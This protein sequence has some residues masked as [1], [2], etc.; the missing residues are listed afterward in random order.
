MGQ[1]LD[2]YGARWNYRSLPQ[3]VEK[4]FP[5]N[6]HTNFRIEKFV[7]ICTEFSENSFFSC[8]QEIVMPFRPK[9]DEQIKIAGVVY[10]FTEHPSAKGMPYG[11]TGRR[12][13]V[14]QLQ[15]QKNGLHALKVFTLAFRNADTVEQAQNIAQFKSIPG[16]EACQR[17]VINPVNET[18]IIQQQPDL[19]YAVL[20]PWVQGFNWQE[21]ILTR[22]PIDKNTS[23]AI[24]E[25]FVNLLKSM[26]LKG[27][28]HCDLSGPN[29]LLKVN[30]QNGSVPVSLID[31]EDMYGPGLKTPK[32]LPAG[33]AGYA[34]AQVRGGVWSPE[35]DRFAGAVLV[36]EMLGWCDERVRRI[37]CGEQYFDPGEMQTSSERYQLLTQILRESWGEQLASTFTRAWFSSAL[38]DCPTFVEWSRA[39]NPPSDP[40]AL[41]AELLRAER[42][43]RWSEAL[44]LSDDVLKADSGRVAVW[45]IRARAQRLLQME[46]EIS[47]AWQKAASTG[48]T[49]D[50]EVCLK[51]VNGAHLVVPR[52]VLYQA[53]RDQ[54]ETE[55]ETALRVDEIEQQFQSGSWKE[56]LNNLLAISPDQPRYTALKVNIDQYAQLQANIE[57]YRQQVKEAYSRQ[58]WQHTLEILKSISSQQ[59][60]DAEF[61]KIQKSAIQEQAKEEELLKN[62]S[63]VKEWMKTGE[64]E[65]AKELA[66]EILVDWPYNSEVLQLKNEIEQTQAQILAINTKLDTARKLIADSRLQEAQDL[67]SRLPKN[68]QE[69]RSLSESIHVRLQWQKQLSAAQNS[70]QMNEV[71]HLLDHCPPGDDDRPKLRAL[72]IQVLQIESDLND[73][74]SCKDLAKEEILLDQLPWDYP[75]RSNRL[76]SVRKKLT[77]YRNLDAGLKSYDIKVV[78][79][80]YEQL[81]NQDLR[82]QATLE[83]L[84]VERARRQQM[85]ATRQM[86]D[87]VDARRLLAEI[88]AD[89]P[90]KAE[91]E[92]WFTQEERLHEQIMLAVERYDLKEWSRLLVT[93]PA[94]HSLHNTLITRLEQEQARAERIQL[95]KSLYDGQ[96][97]LDELAQVEEE[98]PEYLQ[99]SSWA[100]AENGRQAAIRHAMLNGQVEEIEKLLADLPANHPYYAELNEGLHQA[101]E[102]VIAL[103][104]EEEKKQQAKLEAEAKEIERLAALAEEEERKRVSAFNLKADEEMKQAP[105]V[106]AEESVAAK[107]SGY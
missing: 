91:F 24:A 66:E 35:G 14:Y 11:Q 54:A 27:I 31:L 46:D 79:R 83:W 100:A 65:L 28:A 26:E 49:A 75:D 99:L 104:K 69:A 8:L 1:V 5:M 12:A 42:L 7:I 61:Q 95:A 77:I 34:H 81:N 45:P 53:Q 29:V 39:L 107:N 30:G 60:L 36:A 63:Q 85:A 78:Q 74:R 90:Q 93:L 106:A 44:T 86:G 20:M 9:I 84:R 55:L 101:H 88:P 22:R 51:L 33:S 3:G 71:L 68:V 105:T 72:A 56:A 2:R 98:Y 16:L 48:L 40:D 80:A 13:T 103:A 19:K 89:H 102:R 70:W 47:T 38:K 73:A 97:I 57:K 64:Y 15:D 43:G 21:I 10:R 4:F 17:V 58:E 32:K 18:G 50:W 67:L 62:I 92:E 52:V 94:Q 37:A 23:K 76:A 59:P 25:V 82:K 87:L 6:T 41:F 96:T